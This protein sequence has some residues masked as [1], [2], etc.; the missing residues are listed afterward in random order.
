MTRKDGRR[1]DEL[2]P[3]SLELGFQ[4]HAEGSA[5]IRAGDTWVLCSASVE[6]GVPSFLNGSGGGW[7]TAEY[8]MLPR[9][10]HTR[11]G[12][13]GGGRAKEIQRLIGR[14]LRAAFDLKA[15]GPRT[16]TLDCDVLQAD[17]GTRTASI[18]GAYVAAALAVEKLARAGRIADPRKVLPEPV[19]AISV[20]LLGGAALLD[21]PY[22]ED[23]RAEVDMNVVMTESGKVIELQGT[24]EKAPFTRPQLDALID[25]ATAGIGEL[26]RVQR[27]ALEDRTASQES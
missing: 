8:A 15:L 3:V 2:R 11:S 17:G 12:R 22:E 20:G 19:A 9:A 24:A 13:Q 23:V 27:A 21:L 16:I 26:C 5:L 10:T 18:T 7:V 4:K 1:H 14:A 25:L 6:E